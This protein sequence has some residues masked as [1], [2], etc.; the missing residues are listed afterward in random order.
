MNATGEYD[1]AFSLGQA[2]ACSMTLREANLQ[3][4]SFPLDWIADGTL[5]SRVDLLVHRFDHW[6]EKEDFVY[7]GR[8]PINGLGMFR[9]RKTGFNHLHDFSDGPIENSL[10]KVV[11]KYA[12][13]E[14]RLFRLIEGARRVLVVYINSAQ[15]GID[16][17][18][19]LEDLVKAREDMS[20]AF[21]GAAFDIVHF[22][23]DREV[24]F[25]GRSVTTPADGVTE[26]SFDYYD[27]ATD[28]RYADTAKALLSLGISVCDYRTDAERKA[29]NLKNDMKKYKVSTRLGLFL[30][31]TRERLRR[32][33]AFLP[34][35]SIAPFAVCER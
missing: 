16:R 24:P 32:M 18:P 15:I 8:N 23:I 19:S 35:A 34:I 27:K 17:A 25:D 31:K 28:V 7:N 3:F 6:L 33:L 4:A 12:R 26:I 2:C 29:H 13:R 21:P 5:P 22:S 1:V 20:R 10:A 14:Q 9:N 11:A 30:A